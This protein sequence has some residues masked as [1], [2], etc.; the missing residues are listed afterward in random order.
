MTTTSTPPWSVAEYHA[1]DRISSSQLRDFRRSRRAYHG[2]HVA[3]T[4][5][6]IAVTPAMELG[7]LVDDLLLMPDSASRWVVAP[8]CD[9]RTKAGKEAYSEFL[10]TI[11]DRR[12]VSRETMDTA[13]A[14]LA[15]IR[16]SAARPIL[17]LPGEPQRAVVW[18]D[19]GTGLPCR[20]LPDL[21]VPEVRLVADLKTTTDA[22]PDAFTRKIAQYEYHAQAAWYVD[23]L[24]RLTGERHTFAFFV[25]STIQPHEVAVY[26]LAESALHLGRAL[27]AEAIRGIAECIESGE[28]RSKWE[29]DMRSIDVPRWCYGGGA[30]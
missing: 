30:P 2:R 22:S 12:V 24:T 9:R 29:T 27:N 4:L 1:S 8:E 10:A 23:A 15:A 28:W 14:V 16:A 7:S 6:P 26:E 11:G 13:E 20:A 3:R 19:E 21:V 5:P 25:A 17:D 18:D